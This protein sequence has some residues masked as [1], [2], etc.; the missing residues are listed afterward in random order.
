MILP[1]LAGIWLDRKLG[2]MVVFVLLGMFLGMGMG[3]LH[4]LQIV[5]EGKKP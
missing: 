3:F 4:L 1:V 2:T 5:R